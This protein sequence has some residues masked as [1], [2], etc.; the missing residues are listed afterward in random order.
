MNV[1]QYFEKR[2]GFLVHLLVEINF[3]FNQ[4]KKLNKLVYP[5]FFDLY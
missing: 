1:Y 3:N 2:T 5:L 4:M